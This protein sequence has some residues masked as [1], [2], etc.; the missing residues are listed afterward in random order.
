MSSLSDRLEALR[1]RAA[2]P[3][4][5][6]IP[7]P[8]MAERVERL[9]TLPSETWATAGLA[10]DGYAAAAEDEWPVEITEALERLGWAERWNP[11]ALRF[12]VHPVDE[13]SA[14]GMI[15]GVKGT[16]FELAVEDRVEAGHVD[17]PEEAD[18]LELAENLSQPGWDAELLHGDEVVGVVQMKA[19]KAL[20]HLEQHFERY[21]EIE[22]VIATHEVAEAAMARGLGVI[23]GGVSNAELVTALQE[24]VDSL[25]AGSF[26]REWIP[27]TGL[28]VVMLRVVLAHGNG[29]SFDEVKQMLAEEGITLT[30]VHA[31]GLVVETAS[32][33]VFLRPV[34]SVAVRMGRQR[35]KVQQAA[36]QAL[37]QQLALAS[38]LSERSRALTI[39]T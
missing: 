17:L 38:A 12:L 1:L 13:S 31:A 3:G 14:N 39:A 9:R 21:P 11:R 27:V 7:W 32:G 25:D 6:P 35:W 20:A 23:D 5:A 33:A 29:A 26:V 16:M 4:L 15:N 2:S 24:S 36:R 30:A 8:T 34:T 22:H 37:V 10:I 28:S 19:T 18:G